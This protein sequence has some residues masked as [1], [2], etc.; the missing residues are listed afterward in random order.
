MCDRPPFSFLSTNNESY[1]P[2]ELTRGGFDSQYNN[3]CSIWSR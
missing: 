1:A 3:C 2:E